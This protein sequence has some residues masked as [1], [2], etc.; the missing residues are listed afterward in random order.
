MIL[1]PDKCYFLTV[2][3]HDAQPNFSYV[4]ITIKNVSEEKILSI[5]TDNKPTFK[6]KRLIKNLM[7]WLE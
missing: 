3:F 6:S 4:N 2:G 7:H 1:N 5:T